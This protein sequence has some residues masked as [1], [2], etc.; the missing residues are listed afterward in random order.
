MKI[1]S[2]VFLLLLI[3]FASPAVA[4]ATAWQQVWKSETATEEVTRERRSYDV[5]D[6]LGDGSAWEGTF[7][8]P[9]IRTPV[10]TRR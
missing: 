10:V 7:R 6:S 4:G 1:C 9:D 8:L 2:G 5:S 3:F